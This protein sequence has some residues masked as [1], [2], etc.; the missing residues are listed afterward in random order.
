VAGCLAAGSPRLHLR[1]D[2]LALHCSLL[3]VALYKAP[4]PP[5]GPASGRHMPSLLPRILS[6]GR[7]LLAGWWS[8]IVAGVT[9]ILCLCRSCRG[10]ATFGDTAIRGILSSLLGSGSPWWSR[11]P[12]AGATGPLAGA[13]LPYL[14][15]WRLLGSQLADSAALGI[16]P[17][18]SPRQ[19]EREETR[20]GE[21]I[22]ESG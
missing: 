20:E 14:T 11:Q 10:Q 3:T 17:K 16:P 9:P 18:S 8:P 19:S 21:W 5:F 13:S 7:L 4:F 12:D 15:P 2:L 6:W 22:E 1:R